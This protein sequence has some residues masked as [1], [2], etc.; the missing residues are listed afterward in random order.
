M[1]Q[2]ELDE[3]RRQLIA[4][5]DHLTR[6][7]RELREEVQRPLA[8]DASGGL[9]NTQVDPADVAAHV[10]ETAVALTV[11]HSEERQR[12]EIA[13][14]LERIDVGTFGTCALCGSKIAKSRLRAVPFARHCAPCEAKAGV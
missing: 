13:A 11:I 12:A 3:Y 14:A 7:D 6:Q 1:T 5:Q 10:A 4:L 8:A 9:A 2:R